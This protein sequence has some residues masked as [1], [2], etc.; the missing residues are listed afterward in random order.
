MAHTIIRQQFCAA[1]RKH[2]DEAPP[3][4]LQEEGKGVRLG[5]GGGNTLHE[6]VGRHA[7][8]RD[9]SHARALGSDAGCRQPLGRDARSCKRGDA[10]PQEPMGRNPNTWSGEDVSVPKGLPLCL[11]SYV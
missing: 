7:R 4:V 9:R 3:M 10:R 6:P 11:S 8:A 5:R 1:G 2:V